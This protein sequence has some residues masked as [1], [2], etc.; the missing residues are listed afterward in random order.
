MRICNKLHMQCNYLTVKEKEHY[1][2]I[3]LN[4]INKI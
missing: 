1:E 4:I 2:K 3:A